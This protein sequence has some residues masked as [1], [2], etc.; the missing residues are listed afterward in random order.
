MSK[1][2]SDAMV[3]LAS[4]ITEASSRGDW[5]ALARLDQQVSALLRKYQPVPVT[6]QPALAQLRQCHADAQARAQ[7]AL[8]DLQQQLER[9]GTNREG[10][11]A[12]AE[13][14][15]PA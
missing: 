15:D 12:Y 2:L 5:P 14:G 7:K 8:A 3:Q 11:R 9:L 13:Y 1:R 10:L 6:A 4:A